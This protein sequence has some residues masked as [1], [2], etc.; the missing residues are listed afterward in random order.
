MGVEVRLGAKVV[1][2]DATGIEVEHADG[3]RERIESVCKVWAAGV[4]ASPLGRQLAEQSGA[5]ARPRRPHRGAAT[6]SPCPATPRSSS[7]AT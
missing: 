1:D 6:T 7:S 3:R 4:S 2:V 5:G